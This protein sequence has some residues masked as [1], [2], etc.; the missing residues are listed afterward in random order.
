M[1]ASFPGLEVSL[2]WVLSPGLTTRIDRKQLLPL[3]RFR[4]EIL[5][6]ELPFSP[7][8]GIQVLHETTQFR[9]KVAT[10]PEILKLQAL[11][12]VTPPAIVAK[13]N[14]APRQRTSMM[15]RRRWE[16]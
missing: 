7:D 10:C 14:D 11:Q 2:Q 15:N 6:A 16:M 8:S 13:R 1:V 5:W 9:P 12:E 4:P 3:R